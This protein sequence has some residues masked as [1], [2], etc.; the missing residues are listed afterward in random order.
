MAE[1]GQWS[2]T[3]RSVASPMVFQSL[4]FGNPHMN[5]FKKHGIGLKW[6]GKEQG[7]CWTTKSARKP[8]KN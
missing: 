8:Q 6:P 5:V 2:F 1:R 7:I 4:R 3:G